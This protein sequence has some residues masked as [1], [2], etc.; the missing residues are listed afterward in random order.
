[1]TRGPVEKIRPAQSARLPSCKHSSRPG[2]VSTTRSPE[3]SFRTTMS[4]AG[5]TH[6]HQMGSNLDQLDLYSPLD[7]LQF[8]ASGDGL[9]LAGHIFPYTIK[10]LNLPGPPPRPHRPLAWGPDPYGYTD[11]HKHSVDGVLFHACSLHGLWLIHDNYP[12]S[13]PL[14]YIM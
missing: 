8:R 11:N 3:K 6:P 13:I 1:M 14:F 5:L 12:S 4:S 9:I 7:W 2:L 10:S